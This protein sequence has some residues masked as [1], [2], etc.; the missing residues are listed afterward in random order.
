[1]QE[2][3]RRRP[4][5]ET[6]VIFHREPEFEVRID[7]ASRVLALFEHRFWQQFI[8][9]PRIEGRHERS[10][11]NEVKRIGQEVNECDQNGHRKLSRSSEC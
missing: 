2:N 10:E 11:G 3:F 6:I 1:M 4:I 9:H 5:Y 8:G 7:V